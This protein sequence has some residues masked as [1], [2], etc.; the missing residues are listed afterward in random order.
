MRESALIFLA[1]LGRAPVQA[2]SSDDKLRIGQ[3]EFRAGH[4]QFSKPGGARVV[5]PEALQ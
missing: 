5:L 2:G 3:A 1:T 4:F